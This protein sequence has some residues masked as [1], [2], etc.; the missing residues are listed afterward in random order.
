MEKMETP[1]NNLLTMEPSFLFEKMDGLKRLWATFCPG[2]DAPGDPQLARWLSS[3]T[4]TEL[5]YAV[6]RTG[7]KFRGKSGLDPS[8]AHKYCT[9]VMVNYRRSGATFRPESVIVR[10]LNPAAMSAENKE[11]Q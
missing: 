4:E 11:T 3:F 2:I 8:V 9:G 1:M 6:R 7:T 10:G 5:M